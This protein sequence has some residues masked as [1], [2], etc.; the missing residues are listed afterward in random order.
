MI[1]VQSYNPNKLLSDDEY[2]KYR[3]EINTQWRQ[4]LRKY[5]GR[6]ALKDI[7]YDSKECCGKMIFK[8]GQLKGII[9]YIVYEKK[10]SILYLATGE[11]GYGSRL[12]NKVKQL[13]KDIYV[14]NA[15][16]SAI[17]FYK[18]MG[19]T[20]KKKDIFNTFTF[21]HKKGV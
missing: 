11:K 20:Y 10:I 12:I 16:D 5:I 1:T 19:M 7:H 21:K 3:K 14:G 4:K 8:D 15:S 13:K 9:T 6:L 18:K 2:K 17:D